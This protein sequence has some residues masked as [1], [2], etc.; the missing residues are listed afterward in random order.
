MSPK[1]RRVSANLNTSLLTAERSS[2]EDE[3]SSEPPVS[4]K[5]EVEINLELFQSIANKSSALKEI[6]SLNIQTVE[7]ESVSRCCSPNPFQLFK[8]TPKNPPLGRFEID[9]RVKV[10]YRSGGDINAKDEG[11][12]TLLHF[13]ADF[14]HESL[15]FALS[16]LQSGADVNALDNMDRTALHTAILRGH[17][18]MV[19]ILLLH[20]AH[21]NARDKTGVTPLNLAYSRNQPIYCFL[22]KKGANINTIDKLGYA[23]LHYAVMH[24]DKFIFDL[25][26]EHKANPNIKDALGN[27]AMHYAA[28]RGYD[29]YIRA[30]L[31]YKA[32]KN[33]LNHS[34][35]TPSNLAASSGH[36]PCVTLLQSV[37]EPWCCLIC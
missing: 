16:L 13:A 35:Q 22:I 34:K 6:K 12:K 19:G 36:Q 31:A 3:K 4:E 11:G 33:I 17:K 5:N 14:Q 10:F 28:V 21:I 23:P 30:L 29:H 25:L 27:T 20:G 15:D 26:L 32:K 37:S 24:D 8:P 1:L 18:D 9:N 7:G 2:A